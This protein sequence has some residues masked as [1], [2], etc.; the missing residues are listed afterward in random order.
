VSGLDPGT[1]QLRIVVVSGSQSVAESAYF[2]L[3]D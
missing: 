2:T 3:Q 1:Y